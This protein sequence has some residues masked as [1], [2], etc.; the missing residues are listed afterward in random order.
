M[1][2]FRR[3][4]LKLLTSVRAIRAYFVASTVTLVVSPGRTS[5]SISGIE[6]H[7]L[8]DKVTTRIRHRRAEPNDRR[9]DL[10]AAWRSRL[11]VIKRLQHLFGASADGDAVRQIDPA[12]RAC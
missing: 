3:G 12:D 10:C 2:F 5:T 9:C 8:L 1:D 4:G 11:Q 7:E 6:V